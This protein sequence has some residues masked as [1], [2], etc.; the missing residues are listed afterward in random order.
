MY[1][2]RHSEHCYLGQPFASGLGIPF[3]SQPPPPTASVTFVPSAEAAKSRS[4]GVKNPSSSLSTCPVVAS[5]EGGSV[6]DFPPISAAIHSPAAFVSFAI[7]CGNCFIFFST[8]GAVCRVP[9]SSKNSQCP[10][11]AGAGTQLPGCTLI[12]RQSRYR[13]PSLT[14]W[15]AQASKDS[16]ARSK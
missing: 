10:A 2:L 3:P 1:A 11:F 5:R 8:S 13:S 4:I 16:G 14:A 7:F 9:V 6:V 15:F 12:G